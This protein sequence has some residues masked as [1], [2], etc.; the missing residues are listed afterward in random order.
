MV[1]GMS[2]LSPPSRNS[3]ESSRDKT[4]RSLSKDS[5]LSSDS[6]RSSL[7]SSSEFED[8]IDGSSSEPQFTSPSLPTA[9]E[10]L[11]GDQLQSRWRPWKPVVTAIMESCEEGTTTDLA[12]YDLQ[13]NAP[14]D[15]FEEVY[16]IES[17]T[18]NRRRRIAVTRLSANVDNIKS[19]FQATFVASYGGRETV[20]MRLR[21]TDIVETDN[22]DDTD[23]QRTSRQL[24]EL[25]RIIVNSDYQ[26]SVLSDFS[27]DESCGGSGSRRSSVLSLY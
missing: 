5:V 6:G 12:R 26:D 9:T 3:L 1:V 22:E 25:P 4:T 21:F 20:D 19:H 15:T 17:P 11:R 8:R 10:Q 27:E 24:L 7:S 18:S 13:N 2:T 16:E 14:D 23:L